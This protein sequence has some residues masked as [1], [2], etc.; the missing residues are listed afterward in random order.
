[1]IVRVTQIVVVVAYCIFAI[2]PFPVGAE[3]PSYDEY[4][5][6]TAFLYRSL[7]YIEWPADPADEE[8]NQISICITSD[9]DF[10]NTLKSLHQQKID[11]STIVVKTF[12][13]YEEMRDCNVVYISKHTVE[14]VIELFSGTN[15]LTVGDYPGF[16]EAGGILNFPLRKNKVSL[17]IN[18]NEAIQHNL[19]ISA[20]LLRIAKVK[21]KPAKSP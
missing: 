7:H 4:A 16:I 19:K 18:H 21:N 1:M 3:N 12:E 9:D 14:R 11:L 5:L 17:E 6:K 8:A 10:S 2:L 13:H 15:V 20:K